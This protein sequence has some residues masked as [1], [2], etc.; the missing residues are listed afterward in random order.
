MDIGLYIAP[1]Y[2]DNF[3]INTQTQQNWKISV[4]AMPS[5]N[6]QIE[7]LCEQSLRFQKR[8]SFIISLLGNVENTS[9]SLWSKT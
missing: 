1:G 5:L 3:F 9:H 7:L 4:G 8:L 6:Y 2:E